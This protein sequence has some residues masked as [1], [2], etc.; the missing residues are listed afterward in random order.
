MV[1][2]KG[3]EHQ[4]YTE[5]GARI[6]CGCVVLSADQ[7]EVLLISSES[8]P[9]KWILPKGGAE[10]DETLEQSACRETWEESGARG[11]IQELIGEFTDTNPKRPTLYYFYNMQITELSEDWPEKYKRRRT[12]MKY[13]DAVEVLKESNRPQL[14]DALIKSKLN[15]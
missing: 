6:V 10:T 12:W 1:S 4:K 11:V 15:R 9:K 7:S 2:R 14:L 8:H 13:A 3:R 5:S